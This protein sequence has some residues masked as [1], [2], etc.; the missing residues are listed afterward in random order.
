MKRTLSFSPLKSVKKRL[1]IPLSTAIILLITSFVIV[2][3]L[4][5]ESHTRHDTQQ[6]LSTAKKGLQHTLENQIKLMES[7]ENDLVNDP[8]L[9]KALKEK[10]RKQLLDYYETLNQH[11]KSIHSIT[12]FYFHLP[13]RSN[14]VRLHQPQRF[15][16]IISRHTLLEAERTRKLSAGL[17]LGSFGTFTL[18]VVKPVFA[19]GELIGY[20]E[21]GKEI[22]DILSNVQQHHKVELA[23]LV[24][25]NYLDKEAWEKGMIML[26][27]AHNWDAYKDFAIS[28]SSNEEL[29]HSL[30]KLVNTNQKTELISE[31][32]LQ[33]KSWRVILSPLYDAQD[34]AVARLMILS[35]ISDTRAILHRIM[36]YMAIGVTILTLLLFWFLYLLLRKTDRDIIL[37][38]RQKI[39]AER[40]SKKSEE[41][42]KLAMSIANDGIW[43]WDMRT[44]RVVFDPRY[45][46]MSGYE[47]NEYPHQLEEWTKRV[48]PEDLDNTMKDVDNYLNGRTND[49]KTEFR[50]LQKNGSY[51]WVLGQGKIV[52]H[53]TDGSPLRFVGTHSDISVRKEQEEYITHQAYYDTLTNLPNRLLSLDRLTQ[54]LKDSKR[55]KSHVAVLFLDLDDFKK[56]NDTLG[57]E[58]GDHLLVEASTRLLKLLRTEDTLGRLGGDEFIVL[59]KNLRQPTDA[60][61][62][63]EKITRDFAKPFKVDGRE[64]VLGIS[65]GI[66]LYPDNG[67]TP[68]ELL[69]NAD[70]AMYVSK[71]KGRNNYTYFSSSMNEKISRR[72]ELEE[73]LHNA[74][75]NKEFT[76]FF[77]PQIDMKTDKI[78]AAEA[79]LRWNNPQLGMVTPDEFIPI[80]EHTGQ[81]ISIGQFVLDQSIQMAAKVQ[82][83]YIPNFKIAV[84]LSPRQFRDPE[85]IPS[86]KE[87]LDNSSLQERTL[88]LEIT[89]G[90]LLS[91]H[92][93]ITKALDQLHEMDIELAMDDFGT[94]YSSLSY[95]RSYPFDILKIDRSF[96]ND[97]SHNRADRE[98]VNATI[99]MSH[100]LGIRVVAEGVETHDQLSHLKTKKCDI[101]QGYYFSKPI[102]EDE[103][104][105]LLKENKSL[106]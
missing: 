63:A 78:I 92:T 14:L 60:G 69:R 86:I 100:A 26:H 1:F 81:I 10:D 89:E 24:P 80:A 55:D 31:V 42:L 40:K 11:Y 65:I 38:N 96:I 67:A 82:K 61:I 23:L 103:F 44:N 58:A 39:K 5:Q 101:A 83:E 13:D 29:T 30:V 43:D 79:L 22:E 84:N 19:Q 51:M 16:D 53:D 8:L 33:D 32:D 15:G 3:F 76:V 70:S 104:F 73:Q 88:E 56:V 9:Y 21:L 105:T 18:R 106:I 37:Q 46:T 72:L 95:L 7:L 75:D 54:L 52:E 57:H 4:L 85:L 102:P 27:R 28:Y 99:A 59:L 47:V 6:T 41:R 34:E 93:F 77:Q 94:G 49:Y 90:V 98:L 25:K 68:S 20:V 62:V 97:I 2:L 91:G 71:E 45:F 35:D 87:S 66:A 64:L 50:F 48:H 74:L 12:H 17:E 36:L